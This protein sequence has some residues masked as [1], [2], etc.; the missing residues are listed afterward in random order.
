MKA[1]Y[2]F[3]K[4][5]AHAGKAYELPAALL[6][7]IIKTTTPSNMAMPMMIAITGHL[8]LDGDAANWPGWLVAGAGN[9]TAGLLG[10]TPFDGGPA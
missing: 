10:G 2:S 7:Y 9:V 5:F 1:E 3:V 8:E 4:S 6:L